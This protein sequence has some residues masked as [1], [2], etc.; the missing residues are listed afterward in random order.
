MTVC[1]ALLSVWC[2][3]QVGVCRKNV[4][5]FL[6]QP[7][8]ALR[9][10]FTLFLSITIFCSVAEI[11]TCT[12]FLGTT[13]SCSVAETYSLLVQPFSTPWQKCTLFLG[14]AFS[15][16]VAETYIVYWCS[17][18]YS[19]TEMYIIP[20]SMVETYIVSWYRLSLLQGKNVN[21]FLVQSFSAW[22]Q[23]CT[24]FLGQHFFTWWHQCTL[25][26]EPAFFH[27]S[28]VKSVSTWLSAEEF[29]FGSKKL[30]CRI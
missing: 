4:H 5:C 12:L 10:K 8:S 1:A 27:S 29:D 15:C 26:L 24:L 9:Q 25:F 17:L 19:L 30:I 2:H 7:F 18:F 16:S 6:S 22:L 13:F 23:K 3:E 20:C 14:T 28:L 11:H 21:F